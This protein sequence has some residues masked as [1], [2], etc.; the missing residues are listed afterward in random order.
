MIDTFYLSLPKALQNFA[1]SIYGSRMYRQRFYGSLPKQYRLIKSSCE[2][3]NIQNQQLQSQRFS[4]L[5]FHVSSTVPFYRKI[6]NNNKL[7]PLDVTV[8]NYKDF[9]PVIDKAAILASPE[10]FIADGWIKDALTFQTSGTTGS[11]MTIYSSR[12]ARRINYHFFERILNEYGASY[13]SK[14]TTFAGRILYRDLKRDAARYDYYNQTQYL[15]SYKLSADTVALYVQALNYWWPSYI[16]GYPSILCELADLATHKELKLSFSP[17]LVLTSSETL[18]P[19]MASKIRLFFNCPLVDH[20]GSTEM[21]LSAYSKNGKYYAH[22]LYA[23][24]ELKSLDEDRYSLVTTSLVNFA[25][26]LIRYDIGDV[27]RTKKPDNVYEYSAIEGRADDVVLTPE[28]R[29]VGRLDPVFKGVQGIRLAQ[30]VQHKIDFIE[31]RIVPSGEKNL[32]SEP[33]LLKNLQSRT[34]SKISFTFTYHS[35]I[36]RT[37]RGKF[38]SVIS[39]V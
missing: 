9:F 6:F 33:L 32:V 5:M 28:G 22:P 3:L 14:S 8:K 20:Y 21:A 27:V 29:R 39:K 16:D 35:E 36:E 34:S 19:E 31:V 26:P 23:L 38:R 2:A 25:M 18:Y 15:S 10:D 37:S 24:A 7:S 4:S 13:R 17:S 11:P 12:E 30:I 1:L